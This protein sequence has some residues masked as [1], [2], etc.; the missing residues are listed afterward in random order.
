MKKQE[1]QNN[2]HSLNTKEHGVQGEIIVDKVTC[3]HNVTN[4]CA[5]LSSTNPAGCH[6]GRISGDRGVFV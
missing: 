6:V 1:S 2:Y 5:C 3:N 4:A